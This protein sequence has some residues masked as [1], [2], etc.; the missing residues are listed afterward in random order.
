MSTTQAFNPEIRTHSH[1]FPLL[2][3]AGMRLF[4]FDHIAYI[5]PL[6]HNRSLP[7]RLHPPDIRL[8]IICP[9]VYGVLCYFALFN[10]AFTAQ[11]ACSLCNAKA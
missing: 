6:Y 2:A 9:D 4:Q 3:S 10:L 7:L 8:N 1:Y 11:K 5:K